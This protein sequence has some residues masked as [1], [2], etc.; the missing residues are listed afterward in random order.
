MG[1]NADQRRRVLIHQML[2]DGGEEKVLDVYPE[3]A[4]WPTSTLNWSQLMFLES[5]A[6]Q[7]AEVI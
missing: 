2:I 4:N 6:V 5:G 3:L 7:S 1:Q